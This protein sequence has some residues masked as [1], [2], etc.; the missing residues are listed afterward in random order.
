MSILIKKGRVIDPA[1][2]RDGVFDILVEDGKI[3]K[4]AKNINKKI[5]SVIDAKGKIVLPGLIDMHTHLREP[6]REDT[7][8][9]STG[10][11]AA[12][13]GGFT[14]VCSMPNTTPA[15]DN[16]SIVKFIINEAKKTS[17]ANIFPMGTITKN[18]EGKEI[19]EMADLKEA[20]CV[21][22]S[23]DGDS[24]KDTSLMRRAL[25][26]ASMLDVPIIAHCEDKAL[27]QDGVMHEGFVSTISGLK[28]IPSRAESTIVERDTELAGMSG[29]AIHIQHVSAKESAENIRKAKEKG[30]KVTA[31]VT[32]HHL[33]LTDACTKTFDTNT[34]VNP[35]LRTS[36]DR[37]AL[38]KALKDGTIDVIATDHA[39]HL[40]SEKDVEFDYAPFG[41]IGLE[42]ALSI[43]IM[44]LI[45]TKILSWT[46]L[47][48]KLS[49]N[50]SRILKLN[51]STFAEGAVA[52][53]AI[54]DPKKEWVY[55]K[56]GIESKSCNSPFIGWT[57]KGLATDVIVGGKVV[58]REEEFQIDVIL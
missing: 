16:Q 14:S 30:I 5:K 6:G 58:M 7:E 38:K 52:D 53:I 34:K 45:E 42:T 56:E 36:A 33:A 15:C 35:P 24:V 57:L 21:G 32:P 48:E 23:D 28:A 44:E 46:E 49:L 20:G 41:M 4:V 40:E 25:E 47:I 27:S 10:L 11:R 29:A 50:P 13:K 18:R 43:C 31:E 17:L 8:T 51:R 9:I 2:K 39:P 54:I 19:S 37:E 12:V 1:N 26:Y 22:F 3:S 55:K